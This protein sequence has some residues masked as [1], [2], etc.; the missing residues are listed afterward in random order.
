M[1]RTKNAKRTSARNSTITMNNYKHLEKEFLGLPGKFAVQ[2]KKEIAAHKLKGNKL[3][4]AWN[5]SKKAVKAAE[6]KIKAASKNGNSATSK[7]MLTAAKKVHVKATNVFNNVDKQM[8]EINS[9]VDALKTKHAKLAAL[10]QC[11]VQFNKDWAKQDSAAK[12]TVEPKA[13]S[14]RKKRKAKVIPLEPVVTEAVTEAN[15]D[16][17]DNVEI[18]YND[19]IVEEVAS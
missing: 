14:T 11:L 7:K 2:I 16:N 13:A 3:K 18:E 8:S 17:Y 15:N 6:A 19:E 10:S 5:K 9:I 4:A 12:A 1:P